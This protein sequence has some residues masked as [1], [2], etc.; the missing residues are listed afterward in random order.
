MS[1]DIF[2]TIRSGDFIIGVTS[3]NCFSAAELFAKEIRVRTGTLP[4]ICMGN[5]GCTVLFITDDNIS[6]KDTFIITKSGTAYVFR[7]K[8]VRGLIFAYSLFLR[9]SIFRKGNIYLCDDICGIH[10]PQKMIRGHQI[11][12]RTTPNTYDAWDYDQ[13]FRYYLDMMAF[14]T[15]TCEHNGTKPSKNFRNALM[16]YEQYEF[17]TEAS[18]LADAI[19]LD[20]SL[21]HAN[22]DNETEEESL[23]A[24]R[25]LY[26]SMPRLDYLF[27]PG[28]DPG[29]MEASA[30]V[31][32]CKKISRLLKNIHPEA[33]FH[34]SAQAPHTYP[35]WGK[36]FT[37][38]IKDEPDEIDMVIMG[39]NHAYPIHELRAKI[40]EKYPMRF[41]PDITHNLRCEYPVN[42]LHDDWHFAL[43]NTLSRESVNPR[44]TELRK[45]H[46]IFAPYTVGGVSYSEGVHD[47]VN[48]M[49]WGALEWDENAD[50]REIL[51]DYARFFM[52]G[53]DVE[54]IADTILMME[55]S[56]QG[57]PAENP[58]IDVVYNTMC[59][60]KSDYPQLSDNWRF[61]LLYFRACCDKLVR[62]RRTHDLP[63]IKNSL[64]AMRAGDFNKAWNSLISGYSSD[65]VSLRNELDEIARVLFKQIGIQLDVNNYF[66]DSWERGATLDTIDNNVSDRAYLL[67]KLRMAKELFPDQRE[68]FI[69]GLANRNIVDDDELYYSI[70]LH[71]LDSLG[72][73]QTGEFYMDIQGDRP[74]TRETA[75]P[76]CM[77]K[78]YDHFT[79]D[80]KFGGFKADTDYILTIVYKC[81]KNED[82]RLH[83][84]CANGTTIYEGPQFGGM[85]NEEFDRKY[86]VN[87]F[88]S[89]SYEISKDV[90]INGT[91]EL[92]ISEPLSGFKFCEMWIKK[93]KS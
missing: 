33:Q 36:V 55:R 7:A 40:S 47:D 79:F 25:E 84:I 28:G 3:Q 9:K 18:R 57:D 44:P 76:M 34:P 10:K 62:M 85:K 2:D 73:A 49:I 29:E 67:Q 58:C 59:E 66:A 19:D 30:F 63:M 8:T 35:D 70:A 20:V 54:K 68:E 5:E 87:G 64:R 65:Y 75:L 13:Y 80:A 43:A 22:D 93:K 23:L 31:D 14:G 92:N 88:E 74:Y 91:I 51:L 6:D 50:L 16:K 60:L 72:V 61:M 71:G 90:F 78:V 46:R 77:T 27:V 69:L 1:L 26:S 53:T 86:L 15:N 12:Y 81:P 4:P 21:W 56:W 41:Y 17:L 11:G 42:F 32:R 39:P 52:Y 45:L 48:K 89:A 24:R 83:K 82:A 38:C 37:D